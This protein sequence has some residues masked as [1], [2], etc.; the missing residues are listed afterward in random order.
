MVDPYLARACLRS[1]E[2]RQATRFPISEQ[3]RPR[4]VMDLHQRLSQ[5]RRLEKLSFVFLGANDFAF[6]YLI[7]NR[8]YRVWLPRHCCIAV[9]IS[10]HRLVYLTT[11]LQV[12]KYGICSSSRLTLRTRQAPGIG[13][14]LGVWK[15]NMRNRQWRRAQRERKVEQVTAWVKDYWSSPDKDMSVHAKKR[16]VHPQSCSGH[17]CGNPRRWFGEATRQEKRADPGLED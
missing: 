2:T 7:L 5:S 4:F 17:C 6:V 13:R 15:V 8:G 3:V 12:T 14:G 1:R 16:A 11:C 10:W 9:G